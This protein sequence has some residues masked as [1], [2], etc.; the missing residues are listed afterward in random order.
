M[1]QS[2]VWTSPSRVTTRASSTTDRYS[3]RSLTRPSYSGS[4]SS[5]AVASRM[6]PVR[7]TTPSAS[8]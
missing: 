1:T 2:V 3:G 6:V 7:C 4:S 5:R 8:T